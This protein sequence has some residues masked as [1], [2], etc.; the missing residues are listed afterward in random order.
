MMWTPDS[1]DHNTWAD[2]PMQDHATQDSQ[3]TPATLNNTPRTHKNP[4]KQNHQTHMQD[5]PGV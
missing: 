4:V 3:H 2:K 1:N 5:K